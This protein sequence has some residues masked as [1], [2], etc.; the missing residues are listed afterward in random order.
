M[1]MHDERAAAA[2]ETNRAVVEFKVRFGHLGYIRP[3]KNRSQTSIL[4]R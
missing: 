3:G 2:G 4:G 1:Q